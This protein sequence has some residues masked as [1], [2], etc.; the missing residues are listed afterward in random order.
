MTRLK[1]HPRGALCALLLLS[2]AVA[3]AGTAARGEVLW[4]TVASTWPKI[5]QNVEGG[6]AV[7]GGGPEVARAIAHMDGAVATNSRHAL[8]GLNWLTLEPLARAG[9]RKRVDDGEIGAG[10]ALSLNER[11]TNFFDALDKLMTVPQ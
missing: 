8:Q 10:V 4:P 3:C 5:K 6:V 9:V 2:L 7:L 11:I 1:A